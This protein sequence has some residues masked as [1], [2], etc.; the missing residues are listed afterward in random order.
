M[1]HQKVDYSDII[2]IARKE[3]SQVQLARKIEEQESKVS[4]EMKNW[5][6]ETVK[7]LDAELNE[8]KIKCKS[9]QNERTDLKGQVRDMENKLK[10]AQENA[11]E[12]QDAQTKV[13]ALE[14]KNKNLEQSCK[15][16][17]AQN[18]SLKNEYDKWIGEILPLRAL[19]SKWAMFLIAVSIISFDG[20][21]IVQLL[22]KDLGNLSY[23]LAIGLCFALLA[24]TAKENRHGR[25]LAIGVAFISASL[26]FDLIGSV[27]N[28]GN[29]ISDWKVPIKLDMTHLF[30]SFIPATITYILTDIL[31]P[32][33]KD[34]PSLFANWKLFKVFKKSS[35]E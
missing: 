18:D 4:K 34:S 24:F 33:L 19:S 11:K 12:L 26:Y 9:L 31:H 13:S 20:Y 29:S 7:H 23:V 35:N 30:Y 3:M 15:N 16:L 2:K 27:V 6:E 10:F 25:D 5:L 8:M 32:G 22:L 14:S 1:L 21:A 28:I 17:E